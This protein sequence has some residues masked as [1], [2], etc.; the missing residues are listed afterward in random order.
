MAFLDYLVQNSIIDQSDV[1]RIEEDVLRGEPLDKVAIERGADE[2]RLFNAKKEYFSS[3]PVRLQESEKAISPEILQ[4]IPES[5]AAVYGLVPIGISE[6]HTVEIGILDPENLA[7]KSALEFLAAGNGMAYKLFVISYEFYDFVIKN[8]SGLKGEV[9]KAL[10]ELAIDEA[11]LQAEVGAIDPS[12]DMTSKI[13]EDAPITKIVS[14]VLKHAA[15]TG[16]SDI[17]IEPFEYGTDIRYRIDGVLQKDLTLP[18]NIHNSVIARVKILSKIKLDEKRVPQDGRFSAKLLGRK[19]DFRVSTF[20]T[21]Y[22]EKCVMRLLES[23][24]GAMNVTELGFTEENMAK[25]QRAI[26]RPYGI[27]LVCGP[28]GS[29]KTN[30]LYSLLN[31]VDKA[32]ENVLSLENP[33]ELNIP[34]V[35]QSQMRPDI[36]YT[37]AKGLRSVL[38]QD[39]DI[40]MVG[41]IRDTETAKLAIQAALTGHLV[42]STIHTNTASDV[43]QRLVDMGVERYLIGPTLIAVVGQRLSRTLAPTGGKE[44]PISASVR[45]FIDKQI[46][47]LPEEKKKQF[48]EAKT[49][50]EPQPT[51]QYPT[52]T[53]GRTGVFEVME[54]SDAL[55]RIILTDPSSLAIYEQARSEGMI[56]FKED[57]I[58]KAIGGKISFEEVM[59]L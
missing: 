9:K 54:M 35:S 27:I 38:R 16:T 10:G 52:G 29:G 41:E 1:S 17:H 37:F 33:I 34:G 50:F 46:H 53:K 18:R 30:T 25:V 59:K 58:L 15:E 36:G 57:A 44:V 26:G 48:V 55:E 8:Y 19:I 49:V 21:Y 24:R 45:N 20:P 56:T 5:T 2:T 3:L 39:P 42:L 7:A 32:G 12:Q 28:T 22:G 51:D 43:V 47:D 13:T 6:D 40:I 23:E 31:E 14:N 11:A 4:Y